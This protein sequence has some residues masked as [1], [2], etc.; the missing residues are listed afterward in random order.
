MNRIVINNKLERS[1][2]IREAYRTLRTNIEFTGIENRVIAVTSCLPGDGKTTVSFQMAKTFVDA[3]YKTLL[4]DADMRKSVL[5]NRLDAT[6][7]EQGLSHFLSG[8]AGV[9]EI[10]YSTDIHNLYMIPTGVFPV[11]PTELLGNN[12][13]ETLIAAVRNTFEYIIIDTP[14]IGS[15]VDAAVIAKHCDGSILVGNNRF[16]TLIAAVRNTFE[17]III[18]TP[19]IGSVVDAAVIAKHCDGSILVLAEDKASR[20]EARRA[21]EQMRTAN[22]NILGV[23]LNKVEISRGSYYAKNYRNYY[24]KNYYEDEKRK[25]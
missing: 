2:R 12:R 18:D 20:M 5:A 24:Q 19:P 1:T 15:V 25:K 8:Y 17:Y 10:V 11:N 4:V 7:M 13:F 6:G 22:P 16:E 21:V 14:P 23:V 3:G 9:Q